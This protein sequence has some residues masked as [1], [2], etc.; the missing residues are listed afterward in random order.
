LDKKDEFLELCKR[1]DDMELLIGRVKRDLDSL[2]SLMSA[3]EAESGLSDGMFMK[4]LS[5]IFVSTGSQ[6]YG[7]VHITLSV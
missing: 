7:C 1:I 2:E 4:I 5:P 3:A 6:P